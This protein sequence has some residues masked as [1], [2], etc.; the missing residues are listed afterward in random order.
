VRVG[1]VLLLAVRV[2]SRLLGC[3]TVL[4][5]MCAVAVCAPW[6]LAAVPGPVAPRL[7]PVADPGPLVFLIRSSVVESIVDNYSAAE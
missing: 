5:I 4:V 2:A 1:W 6:R 7:A 3:V